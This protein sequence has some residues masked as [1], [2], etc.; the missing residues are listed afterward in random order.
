[1]PD[2]MKELADRITKGLADEGKLIEAGWQIYRLL[3]LKIP[4]HEARDD[5]HEA[6]LA[7]AE[8]LFAS[9]V[10]ML[11]PEAEPTEAD[12]ERMNLMFE[13]LEPFRKTLRLKYGPVMGRA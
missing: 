6:F 3:C 2:K 10:N 7:G 9:I 1:M 4:P 13:E 5:L 8:H 12:L 11:D